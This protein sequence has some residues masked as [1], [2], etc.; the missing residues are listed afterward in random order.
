MIDYYDSAGLID[1]KKV[2]KAVGEAYE[3]IEEAKSKK[4]TDKLTKLYM[5]QLLRG[6]YYNPYYG[7]QP[8]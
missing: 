2:M 8:Y 4:E 6:I 1:N 7:N 5:E 3:K